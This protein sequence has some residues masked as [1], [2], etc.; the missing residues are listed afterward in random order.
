MLGKRPVPTAIDD[1]MCSQRPRLM[2]TMSV[3]CEANNNRKQ[4][5]DPQSLMMWRVSATSP[6]RITERLNH[7]SESNFD[8]NKHEYKCISMAVCYV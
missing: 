4:S 1:F 5:K 8:L 2:E 7:S 3:S 6:I